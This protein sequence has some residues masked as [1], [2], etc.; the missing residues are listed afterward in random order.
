MMKNLH[1]LKCWKPVRYS[2]NLLKGE[3]YGLYSPDLRR[4][5]Q[6]GRHKRRN[7]IG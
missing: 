4:R 7:A 1:S 2:F 6:A 5:K 3:G